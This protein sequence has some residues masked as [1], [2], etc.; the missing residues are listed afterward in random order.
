[1]V[2]VKALATFVIFNAILHALAVPLRSED[3]LSWV[4][5]T[6]SNVHNR[7]EFY[8][9]GHENSLVERDIFLVPREFTTVLD[10]EAREPGFFSNLKNMA[11]GVV[12]SFLPFRRELDIVDNLD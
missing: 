9:H 2:Q 7:S 1:M 3:L 4:D 5:S 6:A 10:L 8:S 11:L 12:H